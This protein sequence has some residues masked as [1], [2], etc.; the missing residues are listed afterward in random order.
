M[1]PNL[2]CPAGVSAGSQRAKI[3]G[4]NDERGRRRRATRH[5]CWFSVG[6][7]VY[8]G[9]PAAF[10]WVWMLSLCL[11]VDEW[12]DNEEA[13]LL[14][15]S[16]QKASQCVPRAALW[17]T[18]MSPSRRTR[19]PDALSQ[20]N[21]SQA[22]ANPNAPF[23]FVVTVGNDKRVRGTYCTLTFSQ[24]WCGVRHLTPY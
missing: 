15:Q 4:G 1:A 12:R 19:R 18:S 14:F 11:S 17:N 16:K 13:W 6:S 10:G 2:I 7:L 8:Y 3:Q 23:S 24:L 21:V 5:I 22:S 9:T 20:L